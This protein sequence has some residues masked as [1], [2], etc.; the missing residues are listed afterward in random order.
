V[1][2]AGW[3]LRSE[4]GS[5]DC[6]LGGVLDA[7]QSLRIYARAEDAGLGGYNCG[8]GGPIWNNDDPDPAVLINPQGA[9]VS[10]W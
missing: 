4:K 8:F 10:R 3:I 9:E 2:L 5:Q 7:G 6:A 1:D